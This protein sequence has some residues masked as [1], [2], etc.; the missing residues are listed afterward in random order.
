MNSPKTMDEI[1][2][3]V[4]EKLKHNT[5]HLHGQAMHDHITIRV[6]K[7]QRHYW[8]PQL[9]VIMQREPEDS[10]TKII[11]VYGPMPNVWTLFTL[12]YLALSVLSV[13]IMI[14]GFSQKT[15]GQE[16][17][18]LWLIPVFILIA[19]SMYISS[20]MGQKLAAAQTYAIHYFFEDALGETLPEV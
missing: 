5:H 12:I 9:N 17:K 11:G 20:Q 14:I 15:L 4:K 16:S 18:I 7:D 1:I 6:N 3:N 19:A 2:G 13:F 8:S 10:M